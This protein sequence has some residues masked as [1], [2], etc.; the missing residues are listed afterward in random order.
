MK[1]YGY[2]SITLAIISWLI[3]LVGYILSIFLVN[4]YI[5][6][7]EPYILKVVVLDPFSII[8][9]LVIIVAISLL[10]STSY[11]RKVSS[12]KPIDVILNK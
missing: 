2:E 7:T 10:V 1:I 12:I 5:G 6:V 4:K 11:I 8:I 3:S 9:M